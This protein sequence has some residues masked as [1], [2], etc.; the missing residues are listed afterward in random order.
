MARQ[1]TVQE[2]AELTN[3]SAHTLRYY[4]RIGLLHVNRAANGHRR[5]TEGDLGW[6]KFI[7][8]LRGT[9]MPLEE[10]ARFMVL[11]KDGNATIEKRQAMLEAHR[12][13]LMCHIDELQQS[14]SA[15]DAKIDYYSTTSAE[16]CDCV[17]SNNQERIPHES[18]HY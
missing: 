14:L 9:N 16:V 8:L 18:N 12:R 6:V 1:Y 5:Y 4:E 15:L 7:L 11:E 3:V 2:A 10:I 17:P 13:D